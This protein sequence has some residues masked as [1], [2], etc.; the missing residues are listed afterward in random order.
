MMECDLVLGFG[1][2]YLSL[3]SILTETFCVLYVF[4]DMVRVA[5][6]LWDE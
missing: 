4:C 3:E 6:R 1:F 5:N 2:S